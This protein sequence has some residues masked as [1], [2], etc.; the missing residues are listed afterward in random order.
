[1]KVFV[2]L[3]ASILCNFTSIASADIH[4]LKDTYHIGQSVRA[5][6]TAY[7]D[8]P[9]ENM[10]PGKPVG[11]AIGTKIRPGIVAV[12]RDLLK[13]GWTYGKKVYIEDLGVFIIEDTM[14]PRFSK[15]IDIAVQD[16]HHAKRIG[17]RPGKTVVLLHPK[18]AAPSGR[19]YSGSPGGS[20]DES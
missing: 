2:F 14:S 10:G 15:R 16:M 9:R 13:A 19:M 17:K 4:N 11:T 1:M 5:T 18:D 7:T 6:V 3:V 20:D 12:S 8:S